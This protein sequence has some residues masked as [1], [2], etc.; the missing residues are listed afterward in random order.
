[1]LSG[2]VVS[3]ED[4]ELLNSE[5]KFFSAFSIAADYEL[6]KAILTLKS[7][8]SIPNIELNILHKAGLLKVEPKGHCRVWI[9]MSLYKFCLSASEIALFMILYCWPIFLY[10]VATNIFLNITYLVISMVIAALGFSLAYYLFQRNIRPYLI[11]RKH[12]FRFGDRYEP[13]I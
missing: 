9:E 3:K 10:S 13:A 7:E 11:L 1:M 4:S 6:R 8:V 5:E 2:I 12:N